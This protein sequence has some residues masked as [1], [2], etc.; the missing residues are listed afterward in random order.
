M[1]ERLK[2]GMKVTTLYSNDV[3]EVVGRSF[4]DLWEVK[5]KR[6]TGKH[7]LGYYHRRQLEVWRRKFDFDKFLEMLRE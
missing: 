7:V 4:G 2:E 6:K 5:F 1:R 3:G